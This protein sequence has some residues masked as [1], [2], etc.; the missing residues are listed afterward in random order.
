MGGSADA[1]GK[2]PE[3]PQGSWSSSGA[4][5]LQRFN[6]PSRCSWWARFTGHTFVSSRRILA[7]G[8]PWQTISGGGLVIQPRVASASGAQ[9]EAALEEG[10]E[11]A[12]E[13]EPIT[14]VTRY[15]CGTDFL[16]NA[17]SVRL[18]V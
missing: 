1:P 17:K 4:G 6:S 14:R 18:I 11:G 8:A 3:G 9:K 16:G 13:L 10:R 12:G 5:K 2:L 7:N 15:G